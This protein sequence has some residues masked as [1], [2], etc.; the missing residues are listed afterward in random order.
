MTQHYREN[1]TLFPTYLI[2]GQYL[3]TI[4]SLNLTPMP[5]GTQAAA[6]GSGGEVKAEPMEVDS[7]ES[8]VKREDPEKTPTKVKEEASEVEVKT[9]KMDEETIKVEDITRRGMLLVGGKT[10]MEGSFLL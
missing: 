6:E 5:S 9:E 8:E 7:Q 2:T 10:E 4:N 1:Q 3:P